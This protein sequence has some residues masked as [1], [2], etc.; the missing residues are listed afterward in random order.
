MIRCRARKYSRLRDCRTDIR[1]YYCY[2]THE[3]EWYT[4]FL[5]LIVTDGDETKWFDMSTDIKIVN[6]F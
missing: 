5:G 3:W 1:V 4:T 2:D 6:K